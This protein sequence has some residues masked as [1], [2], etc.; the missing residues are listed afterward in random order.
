MVTHDASKVK[1]SDRPPCH[2][3][4]C[5]RATAESDQRKAE[6]AEI[7]KRLREAEM[8]EVAR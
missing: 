4:A 1:H 8:L 2:C 6:L 5:L 3:P 7:L